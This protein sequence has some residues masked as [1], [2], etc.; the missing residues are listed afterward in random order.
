MEPAPYDSMIVEEDILSR[1][2]RRRQQALVVLDKLGL[3]ERWSHFGEPKIVGAVRYGLVVAPDIDLAIYS[4]H[5]QISHGFAVM[6]SLAEIPGVW[7]VRFSNEL[8]RP[9]EGLYWQ[10]RYIAGDATVWKVDNW[11]LSINHP[12]AQWDDRFALALEKALIPESRRAILKI[13]EDTS[14]QEWAH[15]I[16]IYQAV[17]EGGVRSLTAFQEWL[18]A[19]PSEK[20]NYW[21]P[22][23]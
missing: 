4:E 10:V 17:M 6:S 22:S 13:K 20:L 19:K 18:A 23:G 5:P 8:D 21:L 7:K 16:D 1:A 11:L 9:D 15:G 2:E 12:Q 3:M 14:G